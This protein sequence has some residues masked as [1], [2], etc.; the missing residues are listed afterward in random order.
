MC[1]PHHKLWHQMIES[2]QISK[3]KS[4]RPKSK[5]SE[6]SNSQIQKNP[7]VPSSKFRIDFRSRN[8]HGSGKKHK[9]RKRSVTIGM[10]FDHWSGKTVKSHGPGDG[11]PLQKEALQNIWKVGL[12]AHP[13]P[14]PR[15]W[16]GLVWR[17]L[18]LHRHGAPHRKWHNKNTYI[19]SPSKLKRDL[20]NRPLGSL[21]EL[22]DVQ[23]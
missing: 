8:K 2:N 7:K 11:H 10:E 19:I 14:V 6:N 18:P 21:L 12:A 4:K 3:S 13:W 23:V 1:V 20:T 17:L 15:C 22:L 16:Q 9:T 5:N